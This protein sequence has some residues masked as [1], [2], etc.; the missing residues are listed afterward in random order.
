MG[1]MRPLAAL[2]AALGLA[3]MLAGC[4]TPQPPAARG[5][6]ID[7]AQR[8]EAWMQPRLDAVQVML[9]AS[10][11]GLDFLYQV[12]R[13][14]QPGAGLAPPEAG[15]ASATVAQA[16]AQASRLTAALG[17]WEGGDAEQQD[18]AVDTQMHVARMQEALAAFAASLPRLAEIGG[19]LGPLGQ[20]ENAAI[21]HPLARLLDLQVRADMVFADL[22]VGLLTPDSDA[23]PERE[24]QSARWRGN[25]ILLRTLAGPGVAA[26]TGRDLA[27]T[28]ADRQ[29]DLD[30]AERKVQALRAAAKGLPQAQAGPIAR[31]I[32]SYE[33]GLQAEED[34]L[35]AVTGYA[36]SVGAIDRAAAQPDIRVAL[37]F[38]NARTLMD[39]LVHRMRAN[40][41]RLRM[42]TELGAGRRA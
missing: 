17:P 11:D 16:A 10:R 5:R 27:T 19:A 24:L 7:D 21:A 3:A 25:A 23:L 14:R 20:G 42:L 30:L 28:A 32:R 18:L 2:A 41:S 9:D 33:L 40:L 4:A 12:L 36:A 6:S 39:R 15:A 35:E 13:A 22:V 38:E 37:A 8:F 31:I 26:P 34:F 1:A 29:R